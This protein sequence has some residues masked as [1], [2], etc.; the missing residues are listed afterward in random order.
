MHWTM[1][2]WFVQA[3]C[4][5]VKS[6]KW[7]VKYFEYLRRFFLKIRVKYILIKTCS[8]FYIMSAGNRTLTAYSSHEP[9]RWN[10]THFDFWLETLYTLW[11]LII[12]WASS[13]P[14]GVILLYLEAN[15][16]LSLILGWW[17]WIPGGKTRAHTLPAAP[18][19]SIQFIGP[20]ISSYQTDGRML[21]P[22]QEELC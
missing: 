16:I 2:L 6:L 3:D 15:R 4:T 9:S 1:K 11:L 13:W 12:F 17:G 7:Q 21:D 8:F 18:G 22:R 10:R 14:S 20:D 5:S 19:S